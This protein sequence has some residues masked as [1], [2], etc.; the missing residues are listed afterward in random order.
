[1]A[2]YLSGILWVQIAITPLALSASDL[3]WTF[4]TPDSFDYRLSSVSSTEIYRGSLPAN[5]PA[6]NLIVGRRYGVTVTDPI[7]HPFQVIAKSTDFSEDIPLL[8][9][10]GTVSS[11]ESDQGVN[12]V[13]NGSGLVEFTVTRDLVAALRQGGRTPG[14][15]CE[16]H[17]GTMRG[18]FE[19]FGA[20]Q[21][22]SDPIS[23]SIAKGTVVIELEPLIEG[24]ASPLGVTDPGDGSGRLFVYDQAGRIYA[25]TGGGSSVFLDV[26]SRLVPLGVSGPGSYDERGLLGFV[27]HPNFASNSKVYTYTSEPVRASA[28]FTVSLSGS[29]NHQSVI[30]EWT[31]SSTDFNLIDP[32][33]RREILRIDQPQFNHNGGTLHFGPDGFLYIALGDGGASDD[34]GDGHGPLGNAQDKNTI[35]GSI[36]RIDVVGKNSA[37]GQYGIPLD[38]PF[39]GTDGIDEIF[40]YGFRNPFQFSFDSATGDLYTGDVGQNDI[41]E[42]NRVTAGGNYGWRYKEGSFYFD[43]NG[44][45]GGFVTTEPVA[46]LPP[47][48]ID[49]IAEYDHNEGLSVIGGFVYNRPD[50]HGLTGHYIFGDFGTGFATPAGRL[51]FLDL[52]T[53]E[54]RE[55]TIGATDRPLGLWV[56]GF[57]S[58]AAGNIYICGSRTL[59]PSGTTG[60]VLKLIPSQ[61]S[62]VPGPIWQ[63]Y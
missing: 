40:A 34:Q 47:G 62:E 41:E 2:K 16:V 57:G 45:S 50:I 7:T 33:T 60:T 5:D 8:S 36:I 25:V 56:K 49:P 6:I 19:A 4:D 12:W 31:V 53:N 46:P 58:D 24:L 61:T 52:A 3:Q 59:G 39:V 42:I 54:I 27:V 11:F 51:F 26:A 22:I 37:N 35:L 1:M 63:L 13:D 9:Q 23:E 21:R 18:D 20:G 43:P 32:S 48:L 55:L 17:P 10:G 29:A 44:T 15:R 14:Y 30:A 28:D 38:N